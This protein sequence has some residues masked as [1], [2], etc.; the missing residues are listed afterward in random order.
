MFAEAA[1]IVEVTAPREGGDIAG[2][3]VKSKE[4]EMDML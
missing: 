2:S 4:Q 1:G 3:E